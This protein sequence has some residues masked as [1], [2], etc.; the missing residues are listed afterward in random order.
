M[1][2]QTKGPHLG[3][4]PFA[5]AS[6]RARLVARARRASPER[7][8]AK[9]TVKNS[10]DRTHA[11]SA[12][13]RARSRR[14]R[15]LP[16]RGHARARGFFPRV[17]AR[18]FARDRARAR[19]ATRDDRDGENARKR[20]LNNDTAGS[21]ARGGGRSRDRARR[22][23]LRRTRATSPCPRVRKVLFRGSTFLGVFLLWVI[24]SFSM[25]GMGRTGMSGYL[26]VSDN[27]PECLRARRGTRDVSRA[28]DAVCYE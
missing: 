27:A 22:P 28:E 11:R 15:R 8:R 9:S 18:P 17:S 5:T 1:T 25:G 10:L 26:C 16:A 21:R 23:R 24:W 2:R 6:G 12:S 14:P 4:D 13:T 20:W 7:D 3:S 19:R